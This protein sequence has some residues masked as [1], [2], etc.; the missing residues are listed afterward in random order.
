MTG[1]KPPETI[2]WPG[3]T[4]PLDNPVLASLCGPHAHFARRR[5][6]VLGYPADVSPFV[7]LPDGTVSST[8]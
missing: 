1:P 8:V 5:G 2:R 6:N 4:H 3:A 7:G